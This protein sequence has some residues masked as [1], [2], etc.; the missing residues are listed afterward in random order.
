MENQVWTSNNSVERPK[1]IKSGQVF[2]VISLAFSL[3][4]VGLVVVAIPK[5]TKLKSQAS[6]G[7]STI[8]ERGAVGDRRADIVLGKSGFTDVV[9]NTITSNK[10]FY[11]R[12]VIVDRSSTPN[13]M[14]IYDGGNSRIVGINNIDNCVSQGPDCQVD[15]ANGDIVIGQPNFN[16][17]ACNGDS[18]YQNHPS[19][20]DASASSLCFL[21]VPQ[22]S[23]AEH[24]DA[25][26]M[27]VSPSGDLY[28][29]DME[30]SRVLKYV[31]PFETDNIADQVWGQSDFSGRLCNKGMATPDATSL[32]LGWSGNNNW[33]A[34]V[35]VDNGGNLWVADNKN[36]RVLRFP[37]G[38]NSANLV[39]GQDS[40]NSNVAG[41][42]L[43]N[44]FS[45]ASVRVNQNGEVYVADYQNARIL[46][47]INPSTGS[48]GSVF[49]AS[50]NFVSGLD[51]DP[52]DTGKIWVASKADNVYQQFDETSGVVTKTLGVSGNGNIINNPSGSLGIDSVGNYYVGVPGGDYGNDV[53]YFP[54]DGPYNAPTKRLFDGKNVVNKRDASGL[55]GASGVVIAGDQLIVQD[56]FYRILFW[57]DPGNFTSGKPAD[58]ILETTDLSTTVSSKNGAGG[59]IWSIA[60][61][62]NY[63]YVARTKHDKPVRV[64]TYHLPLTLGQL[65]E[66]NYLKFPFNVL[67]GGQINLGSRNDASFF[68]LQ[69]AADDSYLWLSHFDTNRVFRVRN[70]LT[71]PE[72]DVILGQDDLTSTSCNR[73]AAAISGATPNSLCLPGSLAFDKFGNLYVSDHSLEIQGNMRLLIFGSNLIPT[74]NASV[75]YAP[76][77]TFIK[78]N[79]AAWKPAFDSN[80][81][82]V[83]GYNPYWTNNPQGGWFPGIYNNPLSNN[84][85]PD[86][87]LGD[88]YSMAMSAAFDSNGNL[89]V[90]DGDRSRLLIYKGPIAS[91]TSTLTPVPTFTITPTVVQSTPTILPTS[92]ITSTIT[93]TVRRG[94][95]SNT[96][97][98]TPTIR[99]LELVPP[100][101]QIT[102][103]VNNFVVPQNGNLKVTVIASDLSGIATIQIFFDNQNVQTCNFVTSCT[104]TIAKSKISSGSHLIQAAAVDNSSALNQGTTSITVTK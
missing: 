46:K 45:P 101:V 58:G 78:N 103:P 72:V 93:P 64:E 86:E 69:P 44:L 32:C 94:R 92:V 51:F 22:L 15:S 60:A 68:G 3:F 24:G 26:S 54:K 14:Y 83:L 98:I 96:P 47:Y 6:V 18:G 56:G 10:F 49:G 34:G 80:N 27:Y 48:M 38:S 42:G 95:A 100:T 33:T 97:T 30:N 31:R 7:N 91:D 66:V 85:N 16:T 84:S 74:N 90:G 2:N 23:I 82:M 81:R 20:N 71:N 19:Q 76:S 29:T 40:F 70:P 35:E 39:L 36:N 59:E 41:S 5:G 4:V 63:L 65:P 79:I 43:N 12:S 77:P 75:I 87:L 11:P 102:E 25:S 1:S 67:G 37:P 88:Y 8:L 73:G 89:Y 53:V 57:N 52:I 9:P 17:A 21:P 61:S 50:I 104:V 99:P 62:N 13:H 28:I 55:W